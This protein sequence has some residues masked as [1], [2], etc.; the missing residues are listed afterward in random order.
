MN[1]C[2]PDAGAKIKQASEELRGHLAEQEFGE[3]RGCA[4]QDGRSQRHRNTRPEVRTVRFLHLRKLSHSAWHRR[5]DGLLVQVQNKATTFDLAI[6]CRMSAKVKPRKARDE[7]IFS[8]MRPVAAGSEPCRRLRSAP[9][10][11]ISGMLGSEDQKGLP[12]PAGRPR[13][14][15]AAPIATGAVFH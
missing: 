5:N 11:D 4:E 3:W 9:K 2:E 1:D 12:L 13:G 6:Q 7:H 14:M 8:A 10:A 15:G